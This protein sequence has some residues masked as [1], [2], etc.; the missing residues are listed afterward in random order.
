ML[1][2]SFLSRLKRKVSRF[3][4]Y[5]T[6]YGV[7]K[8]F[9]FSLYKFFPSTFHLVTNVRPL[10][11]FSFIEQLP[12]VEEASSNTIE[13]LKTLKK[14]TWFAPDWLNVWGGGHFTIFRFAHFFEKHGITNEIYIYD[15]GRHL[16][17]EFLA[18]ELKKA[19]PGCNIS[20][21]VKPEELQQTDIAIATTWQSAYHVKRFNDA[22]FK[23]YFMQDYESLFYP[24]GSQALQAD[25]T[26]K[27]GFL[28]ITGGLWLRSI[29]EKYGGTA[30]HYTFAIDH[31][32][33]YP[34]PSVRDKVK[35]VFFYGRPS[36]ERRAFE[37]GM[38]VLEAIKTKYPDVE[39][40]FAGLDKVSV[41]KFGATMMGNLP[42]HKTGELYRSCDVGIALS[43]TN[44]SYLPLELMGSG[45]PVIS[46]AGPYVE[47]FC[48][49]G[50]NCLIAEPTPSH[51]L[52][53]FSE[54]YESKELRQKIVNGGIASTSGRTWESEMAKI[55]GY[56]KKMV[57][58]EN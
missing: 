22:R 57:I 43:A 27:F 34:N 40:V 48:K 25:Y 29:F 38:T 16:S 15:N 9:I 51:F 56:I 24:G 53:R 49:D 30:E 37:L 33:F 17:G 20:V 1:R 41:P 23:F 45:C 50:E 8:T 55:L 7:S 3:F 31:D 4:L 36:T 10:P 39:I 12:M 58:Q 44:L 47:W 21:L 54:L 18:A 42:L 35:R 13:K 46:N 19:L 28:G 11:D 6:T 14:I 32:I 52:Q 2:K 26:Y 5:L